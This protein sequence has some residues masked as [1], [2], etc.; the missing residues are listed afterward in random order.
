MWHAPPRSRNLAQ[1]SGEGGGNSPAYHRDMSRSNAPCSASSLLII[2]CRVYDDEPGPP[3]I[4]L[5]S[6][7]ASFFVRPFALQKAPLSPRF[8]V[9][10]TIAHLPRKSFPAAGFAEL[11]NPATKHLF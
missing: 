3:I 9:F 4:F 11:A 8:P 7:S 6:A 1:F 5:A 2:A 10:A